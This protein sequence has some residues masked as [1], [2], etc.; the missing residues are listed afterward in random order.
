MNIYLYICERIY[1]Q[2]TAARWEHIPCHSY[3]SATC[4]PPSVRTL[5]GCG[6]PN[7][8][9]SPS[10]ILMCQHTATQYAWS[11]QTYA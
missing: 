7:L 6:G 8:R 11:R 9:A 10:A 4:T 1:I 2:L 5:P 3:S